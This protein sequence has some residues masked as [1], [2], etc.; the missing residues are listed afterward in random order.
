MK[1]RI[2]LLLVEL[3]YFQSRERA[4]ASIM[5]GIVFVD[6]LRCDKPGTSISKESVILVKEN[7][8]PY[9]SRGGLKLEK[10]INSFGINLAEKICI[11]IGASTGGFTDC[12]LQHGAKKVYC[13]DVGKGQLDWKLRNDVRIKNM[14][15]VN[16]RYL[17]LDLIVDKIDF[18]SIDVSFIS[19]KLVLPIAKKL[20][21]EIGQIV[22]L[23]KPQFEAGR[24][25]VGNGI[26]KDPAI[27]ID[28]L[29]KVVNYSESN[30]LVVSNLTFSPMTGAKGNI[31]FLIQL[32]NVNKLDIGLDKIVNI[33][34]I[35]KDA[36]IELGGTR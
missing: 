28:V 25:Q 19:L 14:E 36:H 33:E 31:E 6:G 32:Q 30:G 10:A 1:E 2:D 26:I 12:M 9:V 24:E 22:C 29:N 27:Q 35:V 7:L 13:I 11:D 16:I 3:G 18:I 17:D 34:S 21:S 4:K 23:V 5:A 20:L 8:C 15:K